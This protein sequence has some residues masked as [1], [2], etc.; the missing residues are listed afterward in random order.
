MFQKCMRTG[1]TCVCESLVLDRKK[2]GACLMASS[3]STR[4]LLASCISQPCLGIVCVYMHPRM[5]HEHRHIHKHMTHMLTA[6]KRVMPW[7]VF[8]PVT[9][10]F[11]DATVREGKEKEGFFETRERMFD[12]GV[13]PGVAYRS[14][15]Q[16]P[17]P[18]FQSIRMCA[19]VR[20]YGVCTFV[21][22]DASVRT[23]AA[24]R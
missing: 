18:N 9:K 4:R 7:Q 6:G 1:W 10:R 16:C 21:T 5:M 3:V 22:S 2:N 20:M 17:M 23:C 12:K 13:Y 24:L 11:N 15:R 19:C 14:L 8:I